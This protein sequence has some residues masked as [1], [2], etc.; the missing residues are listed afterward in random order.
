MIVNFYNRG[1][2]AKMNGSKW[3]KFTI[4]FPASHHE[5]Y[6]LLRQ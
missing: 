5:S 6:P 2:K 3:A 4:V 1:C